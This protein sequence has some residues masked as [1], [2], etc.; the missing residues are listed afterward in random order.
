MPSWIRLVGDARAVELFG[1]KLVGVN[2]D[3][4]GKLLLT[5]VFIL[6][7]Y[8]VGKLLRGVAHVVV[9]GKGKNERIRFWL[10]Q[11][12]QVFTAVILA[13]GVVSIWFDDPTRLT[14]AV[15]MI[16]AGLAFALQRVVTAVAGY[17]VILRGK[18]F[19][20]GDRIVMGGVRGDV[21]ELRFT[22]TVIM[23]MGQ[24]PGEQSD[25][26]ALWVR[27]RQ[28]TGRIVCV[29]NALIFDQPIYN[30]T[31]EFPYIWEEMMIPVKFDSKR[32][33]AE[34]I[35]QQAADR[36]TVD[37]QHLSE[38]AL[39]EMERRYLMKR[40][41]LK[42]QVYWKLTDNWLELSVR[43]IVEESGIRTVKDRMSREILSRFDEAGIGI[44]SATFELVGVPK[45]P[46]TYTAERPIT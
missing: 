39:A 42:P 6:A 27:G 9:P 18:T 24:A 15:G 29:S 10:K 34:R 14:A 43:F 3:N 35:I 19:S 31:R 30:Y 16:T 28:Y 26:P 11:G 37:I 40:A 22:Q 38:E 8:L 33:E 36:H 25:A 1:I 7:V 2:A 32:D 12:V 46:I 41:D 20:V 5:L 45:I 21:I 23:E 17:T 44:A 13:L 4:G